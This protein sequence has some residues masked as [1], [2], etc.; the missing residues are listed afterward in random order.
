MIELNVN[1]KT[2]SYDGDEDKPLLWAIRED[3]GAKI[4]V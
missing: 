1:G 4:W 3:L 2:V